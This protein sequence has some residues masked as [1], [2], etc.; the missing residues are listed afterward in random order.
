[1][2]TWI[3]NL[4]IISTIAHSISAKECLPCSSMKPLSMSHVYN[5]HVHLQCQCPQFLNYLQSFQQPAYKSSRA[6]SSCSRNGNIQ[7]VSRNAQFSGAV[8]VAISCNVFPLSTLVPTCIRKIAKHYGKDIALEYWA[9]GP[10]YFRYRSSPEF[11][12][13]LWFALAKIRVKIFHV[14]WGQESFYTSAGMECRPKLHFVLCSR[15]SS[16]G[17][18]EPVFYSWCHDFVREILKK[19][20]LLFEGLV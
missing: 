3:F 16:P 20:R 15:Q 12:D 18:R 11:K 14:C 4:N 8:P 5:P 13:C 2:Q 10:D 17:R 1:M 19:K 9:C 6:Y 7:S